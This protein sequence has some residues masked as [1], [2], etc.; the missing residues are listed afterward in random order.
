VKFVVD[1][2]ELARAVEVT[3]RSDSIPLYAA[4]APD[5]VMLIGDD[6]VT[7]V[8]T[9]VACHVDGDTGRV[10]RLSAMRFPIVCRHLP[11]GDVTVDVTDHAWTLTVDGVTTVRVPTRPPDGFAALPPLPL[12]GVI[13]RDFTNAVKRVR[14]A[15]AP[16]PPLAV[17]RLE[18][19]GDRLR[20]VATD[21]YRLH[22]AEVRCESLNLDSTPLIP[23]ASAGAAMSA[24]TSGLPIDFRAD[25]TQVEFSDGTTTVRARLSHEPFPDFSP[26]LRVD[27]EVAAFLS[28]KA[29]LA[30][31]TNASRILGEND[32]CFLTFRPESALIDVEA[33]ATSTDMEYRTSVEAESIEG[34][35]MTVGVAP[36][37]V[38]GALQSTRATQVEVDLHGEFGRIVFRNPRAR[39]PFAVVM[40]VR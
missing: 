1:R 32:R 26:L 25:D 23:A 36:R 37:R 2:G 17:V 30:A 35:E 22:A 8:S 24:L 18:T 20:L 27:P 33:L 28:P 15:A 31:V 7:R 13:G 14:V 9:R 4:T 10:Q 21:R 29:L 3:A 40:P 11:K 38:I 34:V 39:V 6:D 12:V 5:G 19:S 16:F